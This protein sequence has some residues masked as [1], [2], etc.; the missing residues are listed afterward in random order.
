MDRVYNPEVSHRCDNGA[1]KK[2]HS[3]HFLLKKKKLVLN[4]VRVNYVTLPKGHCDFH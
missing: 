3:A 4:S 1:A 2:P